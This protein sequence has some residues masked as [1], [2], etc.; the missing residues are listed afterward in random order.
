M[1]SDHQDSG[2]PA[3][4]NGE[5][6]MWGMPAIDMVCAAGVGG[7]DEEVGGDEVVEVGKADDDAGRSMIGERKSGVGSNVVS[8]DRG[9]CPRSFCL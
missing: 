2:S 3:P 9:S 5:S 8:K 4:V 6:R 1:K 7:V